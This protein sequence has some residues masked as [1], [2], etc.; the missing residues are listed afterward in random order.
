MWRLDQLRISATAMRTKPLRVFAAL[1]AL[2]AISGQF[3]AAPAETG[4][5]VGQVRASA[6]TPWLYV[7]SDI[8]P[9]RNWTFGVLSNGIRYA[10]RRNGVPPGQVSIRIGMEVGSLME[11]ETERGYSHF[12]E[13]L[14]F[15]GS[16]YLQDGEAKRVWQR[17][18]ASF[19]SD[20]N[21]QTTTT[22]TI[23]K[24]DVPSYTQEG[25]DE[26]MKILSGMMTGPTLTPAEVDAE[27]RTVLAEAR[28]QFGAEFEAN[29]ATLKLFFAGQRFAN[30]TPIGT[31]ETLNAATSASLR[32]FHNR[33]YRPERAV[34]VIAGDGNP[35][36]YEALIKKYFGSWKGTGPSVADPDFG[37]PAPQQQ[38]TAVV[39][40]PGLPLG[41]NLAWLRPW[42]RKD[43]TI[44][45]NQGK[46]VDI[47][48]LR[49]ISRR[50]E[51]RA[52]VGASYLQA[53]AGQDDVSRSADGTFVQIVPV[54]ND[55]QA[56]IRDVRSVIADALANPSSQ[57]DIN[58]EAN[59]LIS[60]LEAA[61]ETERT[62]AA[63]KQADDIL[64]AVDIRETVATAQVAF[65]VFG[66][67]KGRITPTMI[68]ESTKRL[69][70][71]EGPRAVL[72]TPSAIP[73]AEAA[74]AAA[75]TAPVAVDTARTNARPVSFAQLPSLGAP[76]RVT[77]QR[78]V[79][80]IDTE[81]VEFANGV[82]FIHFANPAETGKVYV[83]VRFG[84][85]QQALPAS[86]Q[87][88]AW[89][90]PY[91]LVASGIAGFDAD[92]IDRLTSGRRIGLSFETGDD[93]FVMRAQTRQSDLSD[94]L[95][96]MA[97]KLAFPRWDAAPVARA[98]ASFLA[99]Y[100]SY[101]A[102]PQGV[103]ARDLSGLLRGGDPRFLTPSRDG[104]AALT[105]KAFRALWEPLLRAG[106]IE[107]MVFGDVTFDDALK[108][109]TNT[110]GAMKPRKPTAPI[111]P[112]VSGP[113]PTATPIKLTHTGPVDQAAAVLAWPTGG[114]VAETYESRKLELLSQIFSDRMFDQLREAE[115]ASY[116][117]IVDSSWPT[118]FASGGNIAVI[119]Q[120]KPEGVTHFFQLSERIANDLVTRPVTADEMQR[121]VSPMKERI[122]RAST[123][124]MFW[125][126]NLEGATFDD[127][128]I[129]VLRTILAD[130]SRIT[131]AEIQETAKRWLRPATAFRLMVVPQGR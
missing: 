7:G 91:A 2:F 67:I 72:T 40:A 104:A 81:V 92:A 106:P 123:G 119:A 108:A 54:G 98:R 63:S 26:S 27:R 76:G 69:F 128:R 114:G 75:I 57:E 36:G 19:G 131:P 22:Q 3:A 73:G 17:L 18:G 111:S 112:T 42:Y 116:S 21:A 80:E 38:T 101:N 96:L 33:W 124:S 25:L 5:S 117:P 10:V 24:I 110:F 20:T 120:L 1:L 127:Q 102:S 58:R 53:Q 68:L 44:V 82:R 115:G 130:F 45:Y 79:R 14:V 83:A 66:G 6:P 118:G 59:E 107:V 30:R 55:W 8:P 11:S 49:L 129:K 90:A 39:A 77:N 126:R 28:E 85:G 105:P 48:A 89:A 32:A 46:L 93:A 70:M 125:L 122:S 103:L 51:S 97:S 94:Q 78:P 47:V 74:L 41:I 62:E 88:V 4:K 16:A 65:E 100:D 52:R 43:D 99:G 15:R 109:V 84:R 61:V 31:V 56:A 13:H 37:K 60:A 34:I 29:Q 12:I 86:R 64:Q 121:A 35:D 71:G 113:R 9:D 87:T 95:R 23:Y 50:L